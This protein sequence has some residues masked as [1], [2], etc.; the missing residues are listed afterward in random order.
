MQKQ[1]M[2]P[3]ILTPFHANTGSAPTHSFTRPGPQSSIQLAIGPLLETQAKP[4]M[5]KQ[6][7]RPPMLTP[8]HAKAGSAPTHS[9]TR[10]GPQSGIQL[11][12]GPHLELPLLDR[13]HTLRVV[14]MLTAPPP[15]P[16]GA[17]F[18]MSLFCHHRIM[19]DGDC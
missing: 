19:C 12:I 11:A 2:R 7:M 16:H 18:A 15:S 1:A 6:A 13:C 10:S 3:P 5:Q 9:F 17:Y 4:P 8:F 14:A